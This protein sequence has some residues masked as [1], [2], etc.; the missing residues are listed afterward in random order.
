MYDA[1][2]NIRGIMQYFFPYWLAFNVLLL[3]LCVMQG[4]WF[5]AI[6]R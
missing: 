1:L 5:A 3:V 6:L 2:T 4:V